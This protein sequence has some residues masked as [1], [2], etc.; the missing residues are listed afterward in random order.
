MP[1][2]P[3]SFREHIWG[4]PHPHK[5]TQKQTPKEPITQRKR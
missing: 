2:H 1:T 5:P 3:E 4:L